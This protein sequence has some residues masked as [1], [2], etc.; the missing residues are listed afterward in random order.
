MQ[1]LRLRPL[2][3]LRPNESGISSGLER[4]GFV[5]DDVALAI[6]AGPVSSRFTPVHTD[7]A[8]TAEDLDFAG[9]QIFPAPSAATIPA[10]TVPEDAAPPPLRRPA[11]PSLEEPGIGMCHRGS[12]RWW[13]AGLAG[14]V[15]TLLASVLLLSLST[16]ISEDPG[17][18]TE[19]TLHPHPS[20]PPASKNQ[21]AP[22]AKPPPELTEAFH[23]LD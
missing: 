22:D 7:L 4:D 17:H 9:W 12:H 21:S 20:R 18:L 16:R 2:P 3:A 14:F 1:P 23:P 15:F 8:L 13:L 19:P 10:R 6:V 11:E 5:D